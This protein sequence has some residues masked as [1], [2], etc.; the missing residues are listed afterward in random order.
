MRLVAADAASAAAARDAAP[1]A[2]IVT[3]AVRRHLAARHRADRGQ[4]PGAASRRC[5]FRF[6]GW[7]GKY[8]LPGDDTIGRRLGESAGLHVRR[9]DWILEGGAIDVDGTGLAVT[10]EQCLLNPNRN[11]FLSRGEIEAKLRADLG[12]RPAAL[13]RQRADERPYRR[14]CR[15]SRPLRRRRPDRHPRAGASA[16][17]T[18]RSIATPPIAPAASGSRSRRC[19]RPAWSGAASEIIPASYMNFYIGNAAVVVPQY[20]APNDEA[21]VAAVAGA[22]PGPAW[23]SACAPT[24]S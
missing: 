23:R 4:G 16:I 22:V 24:I 6:N 18:R 20:G 9:A 13:A 14:P 7:G 15:Q 12:H 3:R 19:P 17:P 10:T 8:D 21:A 1:F 2:T 5:S 11:P